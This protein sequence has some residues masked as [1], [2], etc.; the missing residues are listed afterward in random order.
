MY[1]NIECNVWI[2]LDDIYSAYHDA[3]AVKAFFN[4][5][6]A[7]KIWTPENIRFIQAFVIFLQEMLRVLKNS[8]KLEMSTPKMRTSKPHCM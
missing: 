5:V 8:S 6:E 3:N 1:I 4:E 2:I 7:G